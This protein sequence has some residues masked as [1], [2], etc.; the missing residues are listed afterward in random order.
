MVGLPGEHVIWLPPVRRVPGEGTRGLCPKMI[1]DGRPVVWDEDKA[2]L[3]GADSIVVDGGV[4]AV[5]GVAGIGGV[6]DV[7][8]IAAVGSGLRNHCSS[9]QRNENSA[10]H[11]V[12][13]EIGHDDNGCSV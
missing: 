9:E 11:E 3:A 4:A 5:G 1:V 10:P 7:C 2:A 13:V 12:R 6:A 8:D